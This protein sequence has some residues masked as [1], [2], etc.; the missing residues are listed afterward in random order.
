[1]LNDSVM[2]VLRTL[3]SNEPHHFRG[4]DLDDYEQAKGLELCGETSRVGAIHTIQDIAG[5]DRRKFIDLTPSGRAMLER[6]RQT[7]TRAKV[8]R[9]FRDKAGT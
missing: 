2:G 4:Y 9:S 8:V 3:G 6:E 5:S 7:G 1:M